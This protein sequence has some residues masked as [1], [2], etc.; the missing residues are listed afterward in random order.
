M[1][2]RRATNADWPAIWDMLR[3]VFRAGAT[4]AIDRDISENAARA[5]WLDQ[6][7]ACY[8]ATEN[9]AWLGTYY[10][11]TNAAG[12][13]AHVCNCGYVTSES[14]RGR[15]VAAAMCLHSQ[16]EARRLGYC[17]IQFNMVLASNSGALRLWH[18]LGFE[19]VGQVPR[20]FDHPEQGLVDGHV[21][22]KWLEST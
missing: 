5:Y 16:D 10:I 19:T 3:P 8:V 2:I 11:K 17:A 6:P 4:Y 22:Y 12:G 20:V 7:A 13:G 15:G 9:G 21:M 1:M 14:A 18:R